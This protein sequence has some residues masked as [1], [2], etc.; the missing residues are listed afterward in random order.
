MPFTMTSKLAF[1]ISKVDAEEF[2][3][4]ASVGSMSDGEESQ[5]NTTTP[6]ANKDEVIPVVKRENMIV[7]QA[8]L[9]AFFVLIY[10]GAALG[11]AVKLMTEADEKETFE[12]A[13][14]KHFVFVFFCAHKLNRVLRFNH[15]CF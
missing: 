7:N 2:L 8:E 3:D 15:D 5:S 12:T 10:A 6:T 14:R 1:T 11:I 9:M 13:V 4:D